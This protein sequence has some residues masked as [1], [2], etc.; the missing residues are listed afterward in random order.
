MNSN[1]RLAVLG[2]GLM[3]NL[4]EAIRNLQLNNKLVVLR[5]CGGNKQRELLASLTKNYTQVDLS[6]PNLRLQAEQNPQL[7]LQGLR[8]PVYL[9]NLHY[10]PS[11]LSYLLCSDWPLG[12]LLA[13][14]S[15]SYYLAEQAQ[16]KQV[17]FVELPL[18]AGTETKFVL[19][20]ALWRQFIGR[21]SKQNIPAA[22]LQGHFAD[23]TAAYVRQ[24]LQRDIME[25]TTVS[26][27]IKF[28]RFLCVAASMLGGVVNYSSLAASVEITAPTAKQWLQ[29]L[30]GT[31]LVYLLQPVAGIA[32]KRLVK[33]P[34]LYFKDTGIAAQLL[35]IYDLPTLLQSVYFKNLFENYVVNAVRESFL[36]Q[37]IEPELRFYKDSNNKEI[38][39]ILQVGKMLYPANIYKDGFN[40]RKI[41]KSFELLRSYA[42]DHDAVLGDGCV[43]GASGETTL[44]ANGL[45]Y[46]SAEYL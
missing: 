13:S 24:V 31:G 40:V 5:S 15:Q 22:I 14:C 27:E 28:Y 16:G 3:N 44:L 26:D 25:R 42:A 1:C 35:Q 46:I 23:G 37:G 20:P 19:E 32:G 6:L 45:H 30:A 18:L 41:Q 2:K 43:I 36:Q 39:I 11:L 7:F 10:A 17:V 38:N 34:K 29:F 12:Q 9:A 4:Q 8:L 21:S 33:A